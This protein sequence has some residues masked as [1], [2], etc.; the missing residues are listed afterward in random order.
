MTQLLVVLTEL[1]VALTLFGGIALCV[2]LDQRGKTKRRE[3]EHVERLRA[4]ELGRPLEDAE[5]ARAD[6]LGSIGV[7]LGVTC[8]AA[9]ALTSCFALYLLESE[10]RVLVLLA[11][12]AICGLTG[13][14]IAAACVVALRPRKGSAARA[15]RGDEEATP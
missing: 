8:I 7:S 3:L 9:A 10:L 1:L 15:K 6:A 4:L 5:T 2:W 13:G 12:W 11:V 14:G